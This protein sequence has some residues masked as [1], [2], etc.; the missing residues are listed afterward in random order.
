MGCFFAEW[1]PSWTLT[2]VNVHQVW[3]WERSSLV[4]TRKTVWIHH[5]FVFESTTTQSVNTL[6]ICGGVTENYV[7]IFSGFLE[8]FDRT[9]SIY[10]IQTHQMYKF[11]GSYLGF[12]ITH[13]SI[14]EYVGKMC[15]CGETHVKKFSSSR[16]EF[17]QNFMNT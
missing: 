12:W 9:S 3:R 4:S 14:C 2:F 17:L 11:G 10:D 5:I 7:K 1:V 8:S 6:G 13:K 15:W 16:R